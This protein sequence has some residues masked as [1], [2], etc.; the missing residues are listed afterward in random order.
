MSFIPFLI[1]GAAAVFAYLYTQEKEFELKFPFLFVALFLVAGS[2]FFAD[3]QSATTLN[4]VNGTITYIYTTDPGGSGIG[5]G[6]SI[7]VF[8]VFL[9]FVYKAVW[10]QVDATLKK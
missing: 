8:V 3:Y 10:G 9:I 1:L 4:A 7:M 6:L 5:G 2:F